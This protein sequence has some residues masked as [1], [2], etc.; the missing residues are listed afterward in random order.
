[1]LRKASK[2]ERRKEKRRAGSAGDGGSGDD[3][4]S[5]NS[6]SDGDDESGASASESEG[7]DTEAGGDEAGGNSSDDDGTPTH[8][9]ARARRGGGA[10]RALTPYGQLVC[11][12]PCD[13]VADLY[14]LRAARQRSTT[15]WRRV[16]RRSLVPSPRSAGTR[17]RRR[18]PPRRWRRGAS[19]GSAPRRRPRLTPSPTPIR[20]PTAH[21]T[22]HTCRTHP[23]ATRSLSIVQPRPASKHA[24]VHS[25]RCEH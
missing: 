24:L 15:A 9:R 3:E 20:C 25:L 18:S 8:T 19:G 11:T 6:G 1:M 14:F 10:P 4:Q 17:C 21:H 22:P 23:A 5:D 13:P 7:T 16:S 2:K 12:R